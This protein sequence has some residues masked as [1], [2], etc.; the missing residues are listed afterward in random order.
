M[1]A[2][3]IVRRAGDPAFASR[4]EAGIIA[5]NKAAEVL[6][7]YEEQEVLGRPCFRVLAGRDVFGNRYCGGTCALVR[8]VQNREPIGRFEIR[9][10]HKAGSLVQVGVSIVVLPNG[11]PSKVDLVHLLDSRR[12]EPAGDRRR[13]GRRMRSQEG[14]NGPSSGRAPLTPREIEVLRLVAQGHDT[15]AI[16]GEL[17]IALTTAR[18]HIQNI[19][20]RLEV[21]NR[22]R[23]V[24][25]ARHHGLI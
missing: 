7:G 8:M 16:A 25:V 1:I 20:T 4:P 15:R 2:T 10:R 11:A 13:S 18:N 3:E 19:L 14:P 22:L 23:A 12:L 17:N 5:W 24:F 9:Y 21:H 6:L